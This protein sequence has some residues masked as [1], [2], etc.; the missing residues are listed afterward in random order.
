MRVFFSTLVL[1]GLLGSSCKKDDPIP[2]PDPNASVAVYLAGTDL[3]GDGGVPAYWNEDTKTILPN[4]AG[5]D[6]FSILAREFSVLT[7]GRYYGEFAQIRSLPCYWDN[8]VRIE[9]E[10]LDERGIGIARAISFASINGSINGSIY[11]AGNA[12]DSL[13]FFANNGWRNLPCYWKDNEVTSLKPLDG[14]GNG[15]ANGI[16]QIYDGTKIILYVVGESTGEEGYTDPCYWSIGSIGAIT[17]DFELEATP[18]ST[19]GFGGS[20]LG[21]SE[22]ELYIAGYVINEEDVTVPCYWVEGTRTELST[23]NEFDNGLARDITISSGDTYAVGY[24]GNGLVHIPCIW[25]NGLRTDL[26]LPVDNDGGEAT[27]IKIHED[28]VYVSGTIITQGGQ[29]PCYWKNG[30][31]V[32]INSRGEA[33]G[34]ALREK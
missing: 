32:M 31:L 22:S 27:G 11:I 25:K 10:L 23:I 33:R 17:P 13:T 6:A 2:D 20:A 26:P 34:L 4:T 9:L 21:V 28:D 7:A 15:M 30:E 18:L 24:T 3:T 19:K 12:T 29:F 1:C 5:G 14:A 16:T 8:D